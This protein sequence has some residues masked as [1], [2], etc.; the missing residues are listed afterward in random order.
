MS[1]ASSTSTARNSDAPSAIK[2]LTREHFALYRGYL[3]GVS[4]VQLHATY[5]DASTDV[6]G[7]RRLIELL[8]D[9]L[10]STARRTRDVEATHLLR[11]R[12]GS[13]PEAH[14]STARD[15]PTLEAYRD[16]VD[17]DG[18]HSE[19]E[20]LELYRAE[21]SQQDAPGN[22]LRAD[23]RTTRN[24]R[25]RR[26]QANA[27]ARMETS[28]VQAPRPEHPISSWL[29]PAIA[30]RLQTAH[31]ETLADLLAFIERRGHR[32]H[33]GVHRIGP[34]AARRVID[35]L[36]LHADSLRHTLST[37]AITPRRRLS[38]NDPGNVRAR[39][40]G[41]VPFEALEVPPAID[42]SA[43]T[44][45]LR[46]P[47]IECP[48]N[49]DLQAIDAWLATR[50]HNVHTAR[51]YRR[52]AER[53]LLWAIN[54]KHKPLSSLDSND[55][56]EYL[57]RFLANPQPAAQ[58]VGG[59]KVER[60]HPD[61]KP[62]IGALSN[63]SRETARAILH[64]MAEWLVGQ[65]YLSRNVLAICK[66]VP[67]GPRI[68]VSGRSLSRGQWRSV[69]EATSRE[70]YSQQEL[71]DFLALNLA[72]STGLRR[73]ELARATMGHLARAPL[74]GTLICGWNLAIPGKS[75]VARVAPV[76]QTVMELIFANLRARG[77]P[78][79]PSA[80]PPDTPLLAHGRTGRSLTPD[81]LGQA[82]RRLFL[83][84]FRNSRDAKPAGAHR[85]RHPST[86]WVRHTHSHHA[87]ESGADCRDIQVRLG[88]AHISTTRLY[89]KAASRER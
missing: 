65:N 10:S 2:R 44:N 66:P 50:R 31:I 5:G 80:C 26:R 62:F 9:T 40:M 3:D 70:R 19:A 36:A 17:P 71:R 55:C 22:D 29:E 39:E 12:P 47:G 32:W 79:E 68:D 49:T 35:W 67:I 59:A 42:G 33:T 69:M 89:V 20:L 23:R 27:L 30:G 13:I 60:N 54:I 74:D 37:R 75:H 24:A 28:L 64:T 8:R 63:R 6:R 51:S 76:S 16:A 88:H 7:T 38:S 58:W 52:E 85:G 25:L 77:L 46:R 57:E 56:D 1:A 81:G 72:Y 21:F 34:K 83:W 53:L 84:T 45:R 18:F 86:H 87:L 41:I 48:M 73:S 11:L 4:V 78:S 82:F 43:G 61:W 15:M 14:R